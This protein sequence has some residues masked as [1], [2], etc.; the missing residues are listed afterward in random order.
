[1]PRPSPD[2]RLLR[3]SLSEQAYQAV[4]RMI[5]RGELPPGAAI[6]RRPLAK[7]LGVSFLP[8]SEA[9][10]RL[11]HEGL[12]ESWPRVGTRVRLFTLQDVRGNYVLREALESQSARLFAEKASSAEREELRSMA[13]QVDETQPD[14]KVDF[15]DFFSLHER[16]HRRIA[17][18]TGCAALCE[19]ID[20][21]HTLIRT[22]QCACISDY[23][24]MPAHYHS[25]L[26]EALCCGDPEQ[27]DRVMRQH[28]RHGMGEVLRR[29]EPYLRGE[30]S[31]APPQSR[32]KP[33]VR[34][35]AAGD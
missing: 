31:F 17:E 9:L 14:P 10:Q 21:T 27:A 34:K 23:R 32:L 28:V 7:Q 8:I 16:F 22:W 30:Q 11:E 19:A 20:K 24:E 15:F 12:V 2:N 29:L 35:R 18:C 26:V 13:R 33:L 3:G 5:L 1:M 25:D 4:R 6:C